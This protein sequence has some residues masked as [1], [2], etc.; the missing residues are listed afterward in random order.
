MTGLP[1]NWQAIAPFKAYPWQLEPWGDT[2]PLLILTGSAGGG[3]SRL[4][5]EKINA[6]CKRYPG[7]M[8]LMLRKKRE[9]MTNST[10]LFMDREI[11]GPDPSIRHLSS[12]SRFEYTNGSILAYGGMK[13]EEQREQIRSIGQAGGVDIAWMEEAIG[14]TETDLNELLAR[15]RG[16]AA[17][18]RQIILTTNPSH[19]SHFIKKRLIDG[20]QAA[21]YY[22]RAQ[23]NPANP[24]D[25]L[26]TLDSLTGIIGKRLRDGLWC[27]AEGAVYDEFDHRI[28]VVERDAFEFQRYVGG[29]DEGYT[30]PAVILVC[31]LD[32]D[33]RLHIASEFYKRRVTQDDFV[34]AAADI[35]GH[36]NIGTFY[37]DPSAAGL[38]A[39]MQQAN[40]PAIKANNAVFDGIQAV[41]AMLAVAGDGRPRLTI[42]PSC[43]NTIAEFESYAW[44]ESRT[45]TKD[46]P[47]KENDHA[48]DALRY[49]IMGLGRAIEGDIF[50]WV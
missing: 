35:H 23:D 46:E 21:V 28:H 34:R 18:W 17:P 38:I 1:N 24:D 47:E 29:I 39:A 42:D 26:E 11:M 6:Y 5:G 31:G 41:K 37:V 8:G 13:D 4:A 10:V 50:S 40:L 49:A 15:M 22:S 44:K 32:A 14:F 9:S 48:M 25:Y 27:I 7:S 33:G 12:K 20:K 19:P 45:G 36:G 2:S 16:T 43:V 3:K 30:N